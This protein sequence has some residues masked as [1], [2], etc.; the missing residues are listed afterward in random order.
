MDSAIAAPVHTIVV[1]VFQDTASARSA[2]ADLRRSGFGDQQIGF[3]AREV[4]ETG[5]KSS[6]SD[7]SAGMGAAIGAAAGG[8]AGLA[9]AASILTPFG[10]VVAGGAL[11]AWIASVGAGAATGALVGT[12]IGLGISEQ[13]AQWYEA[14]VRAG[15]SVV[16]VHDA[17]ER[18]DDARS[19]LRHHG[20][21][22]QEPSHFGAYGTGL[23][24][25]PY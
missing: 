1:G 4:F 10:P 19:I 24:A 21:T 17:D 14:Q 9:I 16:T 23:P 18:S 5:S 20:G 13:D 3:I 25:T 11:A 8:A 22:I 12:L 6:E 7:E 15:R 2:I